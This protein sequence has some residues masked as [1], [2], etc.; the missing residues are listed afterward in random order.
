MQ[1][2][3]TSFERFPEPFLCLLRWEVLRSLGQVCHVGEDR[4]YFYRLRTPHEA[5]LSNAQALHNRYISTLGVEVERASLQ[6]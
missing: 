2:L 1:A 3:T 6:V 5:C 4:A